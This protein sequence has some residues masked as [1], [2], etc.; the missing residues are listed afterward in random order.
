[1]PVDK[2]ENRSGVFLDAVLATYHQIVQLV[3]ALFLQVLFQRIVADVFY[4]LQ[5]ERFVGWVLSRLAKYRR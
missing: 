2:L 4:D 5:K 1:M 3:E